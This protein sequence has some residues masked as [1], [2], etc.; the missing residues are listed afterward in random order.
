M[1]K[2]GHSQQ[3]SITTENSNLSE[4]EMNIQKLKQEINFYKLK[5]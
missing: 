4:G 1:Q 5:L 2:V 3:A